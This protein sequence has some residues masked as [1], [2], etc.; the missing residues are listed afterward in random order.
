MM[1]DEI[2]KG[3]ALSETGNIKEAEEVF[4]RLLSENPEDST[5]LSVIGLFYVSIRDYDKAVEY[6]QKACS[7]NETMGT[8]SSL[9]FALFGRKSYFEA[10]TTLEHALSFGD[11]IDIY[12]KYILSLFE[13]KEYQKAIEYTDKM[14]ELYPNHPKTIANKVKA[15]TK[16]GKLIDAEKLCVEYLKQNQNDAVM[17]YHLGLLKELIYSDDRQA[18]ECYKLA[19]ENGNPSADYNIAVS[20]QKLGNFDEAEKYYKQF[21]KKF[22]S[23]ENGIISLGMCYLA[24]KR[25]KDGYE[26]LYKRKK[27]L[28]EQFIGNLYKYNT[29]LNKEFVVY[30]DQGFGDQIQFIRYIPFLKEYK[31]QVAVSESLR[32]LFEANFS[33]V[34]FISY[35]EVE[36]N[37]QIIRITDLA[38]ILNKDFDDIPFS[39]GYLNI[40]P[41]RIENEKTKVGLCWE[42]GA[43]GIRGMI[44]RT[45]HVKCFEPLLNLE[46]IQ[47]YSFQY[48]DT[49]KGNEKYS[50]MINLAKDFNNFYD[51]AKALKSMDVVVTVDTCIAHLAGAL[52]IKTYL[53]LPYA[54]DWRWFRAGNKCYQGNGDMD[55]STLW[56]KS[57]KVLIQKNPI[58]W[59]EPINE[60]INLL[61]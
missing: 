16:T 45:I 61:K 29:T 57:V 13:I 33:D 48:D 5:L 40:E 37:K 56:Y 60:I 36:Q 24:Q 52:G 12:N 4:L 28:P 47:V 10:A 53:L 23:E 32:K 19:G 38:Y 22:P 59:E 39:D 11:N 46:N 49:F 41:A 25:F 8:V 15:L 21:L 43:S 42:A 35:S 7:I 30:C 51:T 34:E 50:Q 31:I 2:Q 54:P 1:N 14:S 20:N 26:L 3:I 27:G 44:N 18:L 55:D 58:S 17:W 9:G 6:L